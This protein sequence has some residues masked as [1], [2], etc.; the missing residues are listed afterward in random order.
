MDLVFIIALF[1]LLA[2]ILAYTIATYY[3]T[4]RVV[5]GSMIIAALVI[6]VPL[7][8]LSTFVI[9]S[10]S[11]PETTK[12]WAMGVAALSVGFWL[13]NPGRDFAET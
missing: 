7:I 6:T 13:K 12:I 5:K 2:G 3:S 11:Y 1:A 9:A 4:S 8:G 10:S